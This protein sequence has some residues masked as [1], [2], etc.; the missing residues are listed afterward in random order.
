MISYLIHFI[1]LLNTVFLLYIY[2]NDF[3][4]KLFLFNSF[5]LGFLSLFISKKIIMKN[6]TLFSLYY[7]GSPVIFYF[8]SED[9]KKTIYFD[10]FNAVLYF[11]GF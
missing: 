3:L 2:P 8:L 4:V 10:L 1:C 5:L 6:D 9:S 11:L 7:W